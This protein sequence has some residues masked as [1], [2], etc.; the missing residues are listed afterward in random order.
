[1]TERDG[2]VARLSS[3]MSSKD[4]LRSNMVP[5]LAV[6]G[7]SRRSQSRRMWC[8]RWALDLELG[9]RPNWAQVCVSGGVISIPGDPP[10]AYPCDV[11]DTS[12]ART[13]KLESGGV[14]STLGG[15]LSDCLGMDSTHS[16]YSTQ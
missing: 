12:T 3:P 1:M 6:C 14:R 2:Y 7:E 8:P 16:T 15:G 13:V 9:K 4:P 10:P 5:G 11:Q